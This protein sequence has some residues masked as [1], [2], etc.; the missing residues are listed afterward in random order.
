MCFFLVFTFKNEIFYPFA[1]NCLKALVD[2]REFRSNVKKLEAQQAKQ[3]RNEI[4]ESRN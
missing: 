1:W 2:V 3:K 4:F